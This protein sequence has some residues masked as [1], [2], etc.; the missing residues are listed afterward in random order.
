MALLFKNE[1]LGSIQ[2]ITK[3]RETHVNNLRSG[4]DVV[5]EGAEKAKTLGIAFYLSLPSMH[6]S[7]LRHLQSV[8]HLQTASKEVKGVALNQRGP[9]VPQKSESFLRN[10][11]GRYSG[12]NYPETF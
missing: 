1:I 10:R 7:T 2:E 5:I 12:E 6:E 4:N 8:R 11:V 3:E 9:L